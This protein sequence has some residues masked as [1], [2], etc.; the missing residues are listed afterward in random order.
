MTEAQ[1]TLAKNARSLPEYGALAVVRRAPGIARELRKQL[2][3]LER[4]IDEAEGDVVRIG[5][6]R[7]S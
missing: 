5:A 1:R 2:E 6:E 3:T 7:K 4:E